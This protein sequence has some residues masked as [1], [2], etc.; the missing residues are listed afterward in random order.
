MRRA[1]GPG[2]LLL[3]LSVL[4]L[5]A[6]PVGFARYARVFRCPA[7]H[8]DGGYFMCD[9]C[10]NGRKTTWLLKRQWER[11]FPERVKDLADPQRRID[12]LEGE[13]GR[14]SVR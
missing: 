6:A 2:T 12:A 8:H 5:M 9:L 4:I 13:P 11:E 1:H 7:R 10:R 3:I 14:T